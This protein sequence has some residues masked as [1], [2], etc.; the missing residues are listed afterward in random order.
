ME[1][2]PV[3]HFDLLF[4]GHSEHHVKN[5]WRLPHNL[6]NKLKKRR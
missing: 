1:T 4:Q 6:E 5:I 2:G 3:I